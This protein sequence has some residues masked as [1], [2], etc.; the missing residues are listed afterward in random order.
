MLIDSPSCQSNSHSKVQPSLE[1]A[2]E[3]ICQLTAGRDES[4]TAHMPRG[5]RDTSS[6]SFIQS[7]ALK[8]IRIKRNPAEMAADRTLLPRPPS[9]THGGR[10]EKR[11]AVEIHQLF[12]CGNI[13]TANSLEIRHSWSH[14]HFREQTVARVQRAA[15]ACII[16]RTGAAGS[17][18]GL[19]V[20][21]HALIIKEWKHLKSD[22]IPDMCMIFFWL[23]EDCPASCM[24]AV[25]VW[26]VII[27]PAHL[28]KTHSKDSRKCQ[29]SCDKLRIGC[30][31]IDKDG[32]QPLRYGTTSVL[33]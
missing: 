9:A 3:F 15:A 6:H 31:I 25:F 23:H 10:R 20:W 12:T 4:R 28:S 29:E 33:G 7:R 19:R 13:N 24:W 22:F 30:F 11:D 1:L 32:R 26:S 21:D 27:Q 8:W 18:N 2:C 5:I 14:F 16:S 17:T